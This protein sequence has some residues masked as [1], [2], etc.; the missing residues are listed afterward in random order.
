MSM[1]CDVVR[2]CIVFN[3]LVLFTLS[4]RS[5]FDRSQGTWSLEMWVYVETLRQFSTSV[6]DSALAMLYPPGIVIVGLVVLMHSCYRSLL[7]MFDDSL[8]SPHRNASR[9][10]QH[11]AVVRAVLARPGLKYRIVN[12]FRSF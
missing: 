7:S 3:A 2:V 10:R 1:R 11:E 9:S 6:A 12:R 5:R 8:S 4:F